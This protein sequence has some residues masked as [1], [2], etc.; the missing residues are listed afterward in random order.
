ML[1]F[2]SRLLTVFSVY[3]PAKDA[4][5]E[6]A[7]FWQKQNSAFLAERSERKKHAKKFVAFFM[8]SCVY[9]AMELM[10]RGYTHISMSLAGGVSL[11]AIGRI[12]CGPLKNRPL[13]LRCLTGGTLITG[14]EFFTGL[15]VNRRLHLKVWDYSHRRFSVLGQICPGATLLWTILSL[16]AIGLCGAVSRLP[17]LK[18]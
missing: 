13:W 12:C 16:P 15:I 17:F 6:K 4:H 10:Y 1:N 11:C 18:D 3:A 2:Y 14:V 9:P 8:G 7:P 5:T